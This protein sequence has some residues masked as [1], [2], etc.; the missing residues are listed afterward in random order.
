MN[1]MSTIKI[2]NYLLP[3]FSFPGWIQD[4]PEKKDNVADNAF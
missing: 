1:M 2:I 3:K 4:P